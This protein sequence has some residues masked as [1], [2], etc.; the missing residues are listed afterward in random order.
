MYKGIKNYVKSIPTSYID[1]SKQEDNPIGGLP[2]D[3][4]KN[5]KTV[6]R[7]RNRSISSKNSIKTPEVSART[8][9]LRER[10]LAWQHSLRGSPKNSSLVES[11]VIRM[12]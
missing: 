12:E 6:Q 9:P 1:L 7:Q 2:F 10:N 3:A 4:W 8:S 5:A 11:V